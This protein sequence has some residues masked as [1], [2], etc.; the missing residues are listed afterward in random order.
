MTAL[1]YLFF[2]LSFTTG[3]YISYRITKAY[4]KRKI[5]RLESLIRR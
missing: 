4:Y 2:A 5:K 1:T 3:G